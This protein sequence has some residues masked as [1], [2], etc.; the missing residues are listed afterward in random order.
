[1]AKY[2]N[3]SKAALNAMLDEINMQRGQK[4][5]KPL[6]IL[7]EDNQL[8]TKAG[9]NVITKLINTDKVPAVIGA[10]ASSITLAMAPI[11]EKNKVVNITWFLSTTNNKCRELYF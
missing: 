4:N 6:Q 10:M 3:T 9:V 11:A 1:M 2:G 8:E 7:F 5:M